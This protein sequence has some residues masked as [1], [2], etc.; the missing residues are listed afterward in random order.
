[1]E[2]RRLPVDIDNFEQLQKENYYVDKS[3]M[4]SDLLIDRGLVNLFMHTRR[5]GKS[6][7]IEN[8][9]KNT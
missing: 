5:F 1:M 2:N 3:G 7:K 6:L 4:S 8:Y 9:V